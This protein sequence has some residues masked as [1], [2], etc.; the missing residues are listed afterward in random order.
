MNHYIAYLM[1]AGL[2]LAASH[3]PVM[4]A[5]PL[6]HPNGTVDI[7]I[8]GAQSAT[9]RARMENWTEG[10]ASLIINDNESLDL[11]VVARE[12]VQEAAGVY[13][14]FQSGELNVARDFQRI[15]DALPTWLT[16]LLDRFGLT[17]LAEMQERL[18]AGLAKGS[19]FFASP[20]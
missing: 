9:I 7:L 6:R 19:Q 12:Q 1:A 3:G 14:K 16:S 13:G 18:F 8:D 11:T 4:S 15:V 10:S 5:S 20:S 2:A 17:N